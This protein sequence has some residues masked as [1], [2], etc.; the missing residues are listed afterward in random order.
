LKFVILEVGYSC[1]AACKFCYN[2]WRT[3][4]K[5]QYPQEKVL[6]KTSFFSIIDK[7][8]QWGV[9]TLGFSGGE[10][11]LNPDLFDIAAYAKANGF[12]NSLLT[13]G[14][15][16]SKFSSQIAENFE[17]VQ[18]SLQGLQ[19]T[20]DKLTGK[21]GNFQKAILG[22]TALMDYKVSVSA[23]V[24]V[25]RL[26]L[27]ELKDTIALAAGVDMNSVLVNRFLPGGKGLENTDMAFNE[28]ELLQMLNLTE[29]GSDENGIPVLVGTPTPL[30]LEGLRNYRFLLK[31]GCMAG[32]GI[33]CAID[34]SGGLRVCNHSPQVL[35]NCLE[36]DP[37]EIYENSD[38]IKGFVELRYTPKM[39][40]GCDK[41]GKCKGGCRE[42]AHA[43]YGSLNDPDPIF[44]KQG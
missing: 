12:K 27:F 13:N 1:N 23:V 6:S 5:H 34:P 8:K 19:T 2:A 9:D 28:N 29:E 35:G 24:V 4:N 36:S 37:K 11:L 17:V 7:L 3:T 38:Y 30:C 14:I 21:D 42:A 26:N 41:L 31:E 22:R 43:L 16:A 15:L 32:K 33:H 20:H 44:Q 10:P 39:C 25:N 40:V 18:I